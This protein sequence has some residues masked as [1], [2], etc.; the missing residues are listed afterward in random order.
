MN[1]D[2]L[3]NTQRLGLEDRVNL[4]DKSRTQFER[5]YDRIIFSSPFRRLQ[6]KT[7]VFPLPGNV[8]VHNRLTHSLEVASV[9]RS[10]GNMLAEK[11]R[12]HQLLENTHLL[13]ELGSVVGAACLAHDLGNPPFG[14]SGE[15]AIRKYFK[16]DDGR[17]WKAQLNPEDW[18]DLVNYEGNANA[19]RLLTRQFK[20]RRVGGFNLTYTTL[21]TIVKYPSQSAAIDPNIPHQKKNGFFNAEKATYQQLVA[22]LGVPV[23]QHN[24]LVAARHPLVFL[25]EAADDICYHIID[26]EDAHR[27]GICDTAKTKYYL[28]EFLDH[29]DLSEEEKEIAET[30]K[31]VTDAKE[32]IAYLRARIIGLLITACFNSFWYHHDAILAGDHH[33][34]LIDDLPDPYGHALKAIKDYSVTHIYNAEAVNEVELAG[35]NV[36]GGLLAEFIPAVLEQD[37]SP[38]RQKLKQLIPEQFLTQSDD[39]YHQ[40]L[41]V[42]DYIAG[43]TDTYALDLYRRIKGIDLPSF[44]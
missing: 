12:E 10:L 44:Q 21:A 40:I 20:G 32:Q 28:W 34:D 25:V 5:D 22:S 41:S 1:W 11:L 39:P 42:V 33:R 8:F 9:G 38:Y 2:Q 4:S 29:P 19:I 16:E 43:M 7:Q 31:T 18:Y 30:F 6:N 14:H 23:F 26:L 36:L 24:P 27:L 13:Q 3:L 15:K 37:D 17:K 35:Y